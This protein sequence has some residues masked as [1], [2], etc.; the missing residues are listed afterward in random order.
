MQARL[1]DVFVRFSQK[2]LE[3]SRGY[4]SSL[5]SKMEESRISD[6]AFASL[7]KEIDSFSNE[8]TPRRSYEVAPQPLPDVSQR[9][10][11]PKNSA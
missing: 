10:P 1:L 8:F 2:A 7:L 3:K 4:G 11:P 5:P 9:N 6:A